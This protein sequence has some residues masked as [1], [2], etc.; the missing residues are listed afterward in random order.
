MSSTSK[1][2][3]PFRRVEERPDF[4]SPFPKNVKNTVSN[5]Q[6]TTNKVITEFRENILLMKE[7]L[8]I[9]NVSSDEIMAF[10]TKQFNL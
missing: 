8:D 7:A 10:L 4:M 6:E 9:K 2:N 1:S 3:F 5:R